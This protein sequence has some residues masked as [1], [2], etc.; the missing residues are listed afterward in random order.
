MA[1]AST[2]NR[3]LAEHLKALASA[4]GSNVT[5]VGP[6]MTW[7][8]RIYPLVTHPVHHNGHMVYVSKSII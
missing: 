3:H 8:L 1:L 2:T 7:L 4:I 5:V 6:Q